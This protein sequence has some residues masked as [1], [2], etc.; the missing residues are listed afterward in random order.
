MFLAGII[1]LAVAITAVVIVALRHSRGLTSPEGYGQPEAGHIFQE[2]PQTV[3]GLAYEEVSFSVPSGETLRGWLVPAAE[4]NELSIAVLHGRGGDRRSHLNQLGMFHE[5]GASV[6]LFDLRE[7]GLSD[8]NS[9]GTGL[10][11]REAEDGIAAAAELRRRGYGKVVVFGC[12]LGGSA[13]I[14]AAA[15][16]PS[17]D[18]AIAE[19]SIA[20]FEDYMSDEAALRLQGRF[21]AAPLWLA[22]AWGNLVVAVTRAR[23]GLK[24]YTTPQ[25]EI[26]KISPRPTL[27]IHGRQDTAVRETHAHALH[28]NAGENAQLWLIEGAGH[29]DGYDVAGS[30]YRQKVAGFL[31]TLTAD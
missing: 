29:C 2:T 21:G 14:I 15:R 3:A 22:N 26:G 10:A 17:I 28:E 8:G 6:L 16:D 9:R 1:V 19:A 20:R 18:G 13:A 12:S 24:A 30:Q 23:I 25:D 11:V 4:G 31:A 7:N 27:L 5:L